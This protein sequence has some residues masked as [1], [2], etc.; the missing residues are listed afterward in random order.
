MGSRLRLISANLLNGGAAAQA[1]ADLVTAL[2]ADV[3]AVQ[4]IG[5]EQAAALTR[6]LPYG[7]VQPARDHT[8]MGIALRHPGTMR[9][10]PLGNGH[11][12]IA[13]LDP[14]HW[15]GAPAAIEVINVHISAPH[16]RPFWRT[17]RRRRDQLRRLS[18][19]LDA[20][21]RHARVLLGDLNA[22]P[23]W[24]LYRRLASRLSDAA[25]EAARRRGVRSAPTWGPWPGGPRLARIDHALVHGVL[26]EDFQ[27]VRID[28]SD[29]SAIVLD[30]SA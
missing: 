27:V 9:C 25:I 8:G 16:L 30:V 1:F 19:Y 17:V 28:G 29:H 20:V 22:T 7:S 24:P 26:V 2:G 10:V 13:V 23:L 15:P 5:P 3:V 6:A 11:A 4:E 18:E 12:S 14:A 21:P